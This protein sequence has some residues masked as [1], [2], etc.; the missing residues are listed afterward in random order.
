MDPQSYGS[1]KSVLLELR[2]MKALHVQGVRAQ[3]PFLFLHCAPPQLPPIQPASF[4]FHS[5]IIALQTS[6][7]PRTT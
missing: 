3:I 7:A 1:F 5:D 2:E 4:T 6:K